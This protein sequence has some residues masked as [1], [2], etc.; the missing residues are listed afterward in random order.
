MGSNSLNIYNEYFQG[1]PMENANNTA[2]KRMYFL[3][4]FR[5]ISIIL[6]VFIHAIS[7]EWSKSFDLVEGSMEPTPIINFIFYFGTL[8]GV[9]HFM[10]A[11]VLAFTMQRKFAAGKTPL[12]EL[13][14]RGV[15]KGIILLSLHYVFRPLFSFLDG[16]VYYYIRDGTLHTPSPENVINLSTFAMLGWTSSP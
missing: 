6:V 10:M 7:E 4:L 15:I 11:A 13:V 2:L 12:N 1:S 5:G 14:V 8:G 16:I 3:D 9:F